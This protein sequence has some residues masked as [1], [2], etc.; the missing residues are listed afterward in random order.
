MKQKS[1]TLAQDYLIFK[2]CAIEREAR[3]YFDFGVK[4]LLKMSYNE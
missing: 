3:V 2:S 4:V 1:V